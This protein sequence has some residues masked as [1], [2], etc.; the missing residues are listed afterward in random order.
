MSA[1]PQTPINPGAR[2]GN[3]RVNLPVGD[4]NGRDLFSLDF[5]ARNGS[6]AARS[7]VGGVVTTPTFLE[8]FL[9]RRKSSEM[10]NG[11]ERAERRIR[12]ACGRLASPRV[13]H[14]GRLMCS[15]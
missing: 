4:K 11:R 5:N 15:L 13:P 2:L 1:V 14:V 7:Y 9:E 10:S 6:C 12:D 8:Y 3:R